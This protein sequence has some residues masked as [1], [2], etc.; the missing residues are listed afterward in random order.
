MIIDPFRR[1]GGRL[2]GAVSFVVLAAGLA[3]WWG[4]MAW[5]GPGPGAP[6]GEA[7]TILVNIP[8]GMTLGAAADTLVARGL[9]RDRRI[10]L[11]GARLTGRDRGLRAG[12]Y[13]LR[14]GTSARRLL[15]DLTTGLSVQVKVTIPE[16]LAAGAIA[17]IV[18][19]QLEIDTGAFLAAA[20]SLVRAAAVERGLLGGAEA[21]ARYD[22]LLTRLSKGGARVFHWCEGYL[23]P[24][25]YLFAAGT[26]SAPAAAHLVAVQLDRL[27][28]LWA[29]RKISN[30]QVASVH[31][32]LTL[33]SI[34]EAEARQDQERA[35]VAAVYTNRLARRW[36]LEADP[37]VAFVLDKKGKRLFYRDLEVE[38]PFNTYRRRGLPPGPIGSPGWKALVAAAYPDSTCRAMYF[39]ADGSGGHVFSRTVREHEEA[40]RRFRRLKA[41]ERRQGRH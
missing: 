36:R 40:V 7:G 20:D 8:A 33:A 3:L 15:A 16:G 12:L 5:T 14:F 37:T 13:R 2:A 39:V 17:D 30:S 28:S 23:A 24:D 4:W 10:L 26:A 27:D 11:A 18:A 41:A 9:L 32:L 1:P 6:D 21:A 22:S 29:D 35:L 31:E 34:V 19:W 25:T 38:S